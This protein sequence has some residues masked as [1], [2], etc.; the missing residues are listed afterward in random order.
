MGRTEEIITILNK[1]ITKLVNSESNCLWV[2]TIGLYISRSLE[3]SE[4][5]PELWMIEINVDPAVSCD[6][7]EY[8]D[9][10]NLN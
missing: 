4:D 9:S 8:F 5:E 2:S 7:D 10:S 6:E 1:L 3:S